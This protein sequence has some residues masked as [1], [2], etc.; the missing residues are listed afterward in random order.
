MVSDIEFIQFEKE[1]IN[2]KN[3]IFSNILIFTKGYRL[4]YFFAILSQFLSVLFDSILYVALAWFVDDWLL[5]SD[6]PIPLWKVVILFFQIGR[7]SC[8]ERV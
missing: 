4:T 7:A 5:S 3:K 6:N 8:R 2:N 1:K